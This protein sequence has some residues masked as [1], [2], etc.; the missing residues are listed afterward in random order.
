MDDKK[1]G[2]NAG[3]APKEDDETRKQAYFDK[4]RSQNGGVPRHAGIRSCEC[5]V[6]SIFC[7][8]QPTTAGA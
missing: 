6:R 8:T 4:L 7:P 2:D 5:R 1:P 3:E